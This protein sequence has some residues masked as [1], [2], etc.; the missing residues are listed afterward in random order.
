METILRQYKELKSKYQDCLI[1][2]RDGD[3]YKSFDQDAQ[4][5]ASAIGVTVMKNKVTSATIF[6]ANTFD[7]NL[8]KLVRAGFKVAICEATNKVA[9][10]AKA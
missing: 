6:H 10:G 4:N 9:K 8:S 1:L 5:V 2:M 3:F 7:V